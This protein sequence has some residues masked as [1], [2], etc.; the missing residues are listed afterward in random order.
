ML[1]KIFCISLFSHV[2]LPRCLF[3]W[4]CRAHYIGEFL[5]NHTEDQMEFL[6]S[7]YSLGLYLPFCQFLLYEKL[8][9]YFYFFLIFKCLFHLG[10][11]LISMED[12]LPNLSAW[13]KRIWCGHL[14]L[15]PHHQTTGPEKY[16]PRWP[17]LASKLHEQIWGCFPCCFIGHLP[18]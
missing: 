18:L 4:L 6:F 13:A 2:A 9:F 15:I 17:D 7:F 11:L 12:F 1:L 14:S 5:N 16:K 10:Y 3:T 8:F